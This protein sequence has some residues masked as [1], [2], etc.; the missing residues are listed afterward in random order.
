MVLTLVLDTETTGF[1]MMT[2]KRSYHSYTESDKYDTSRMIELGFVLYDDGKE[3]EKY[4]EI[5]KVDFPV[6]NSDIHGI[7]NK[8]CEKDGVDIDSVLSALNNVL[9]DNVTIV[10]HNVRFDI[11]II[12]SEAHRINNV[13]LINKIHKCKQVCTCA[14]AKKIFNLRYYIKL[15]VLY[16][17]LFNKEINQDHRALSDV[18]LCA[19]CYF[20]MLK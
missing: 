14:L 3:I 8:M 2:V 5:V 11:N 10:A 19:K 7:T 15:V 9:S 12:L 1:P 20:E 16:K 18:Y 4:N 6:H 13:D 17:K